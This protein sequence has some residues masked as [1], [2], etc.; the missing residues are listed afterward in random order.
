MFKAFRYLD[1]FNF[2]YTRKQVVIDNLTFELISNIC[3]DN[4]AFMFKKYQFTTKNT[5][6]TWRLGELLTH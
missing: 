5:K 3:V 6:L 1:P 2:K 4:H